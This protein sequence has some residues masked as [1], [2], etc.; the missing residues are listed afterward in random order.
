MKLAKE[1]IMKITNNTYIQNKKTRRNNIT[2]K[3]HSPQI[4]END[5]KLLNEYAHEHPNA[6]LCH[7]RRSLIRHPTLSHIAKLHLIQLHSLLNMPSTFRIAPHNFSSACRFNNRVV[8]LQKLDEIIE[9]HPNISRRELMDK[10]DKTAELQS[11]HGIS[12]RSL[13]DIIN[14]FIIKSKKHTEGKIE[15]KNVSTPEKPAKKPSDTF[16]SINVN[17]SIKF[18]SFFSNDHCHIYN[19][20]KI[21]LK[22]LQKF[23][24]TH[25]Y[26]S[27]KELKAIIAH[28]PSL[29]FLDKV[30]DYKFAYFLRSHNIKL[31][32]CISD[33][34]NKVC[35][36]DNACT[37]NKMPVAIEEL[38]RI[39]RE[40]AHITYAQIIRD[41]F[42]TNEKLKTLRNISPGDLSKIAKHFHMGIVNP[43]QLQYKGRDVDSSLIQHLLMTKPNL[44]YSAILDEIKADIDRYP[45]LNNIKAINITTFTHICSS[46]IANIHKKH[47]IVFRRNPVDED[48]L[49]RFN[50][51]NPDCSWRKL[52][53]KLLTPPGDLKVLKGISVYQLREIFRKANIVRKRSATSNVAS[54]SEPDSQESSSDIPNKPLSLDILT[55]NMFGDI[56]MQLDPGF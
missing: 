35:F 14:G 43:L 39:L 32:R 19:N 50:A 49:W 18:D 22:Q 42:P 38:R 8:N 27:V 26:G 10:I 31:S 4:S 29:A 33:P 15:F 51:D 25:K 40:H 1:L 23:A 47:N 11:I 54:I 56:D 5:I 2:K 28:Y 21:D 46:I 24:N 7:L 20:H 36:K 17:N 53:K 45:T 44:S 6:S 30:E 52:A 48:A 9:A 13:S 3:R 41:I 16:S 55:S 12:Y 34:I 37:Y